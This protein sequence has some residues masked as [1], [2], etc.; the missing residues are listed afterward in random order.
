V[1]KV[2]ELQK[3][4]RMSSAG[5]AASAR[6]VASERSAYPL[7]RRPWA[8]S[9]PLRREFGVDA[10]AWG[11]FRSQAPSYRR[12]TVRWVMSAKRE[13]TRRRRL[14]VLIGRSRGLRRIDLLSPG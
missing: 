7:G 11:F 5:L 9:P 13:Q 10:R 6:R 3:A 12:T 4:G 14:R 8:L 2:I 1:R